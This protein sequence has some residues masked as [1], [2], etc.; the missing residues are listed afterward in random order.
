MFIKN[1]L[2]FF[3]FNLLFSGGWSITVE[4]GYSFPPVS[5]S[6]QSTKIGKLLKSQSNFIVNYETE[7]M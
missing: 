5:T 7:N 4:F 1:P 3:D 6:V 2:T